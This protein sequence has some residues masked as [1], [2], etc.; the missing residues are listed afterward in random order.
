MMV[1]G[2]FFVKKSRFRQDDPFSRRPYLPTAV[3]PMQLVS[4]ADHCPPRPA[5][6]ST[7]TRA[8]ILVNRKTYRFFRS[9]LAN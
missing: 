8:H 5:G 2:P 7:D 9:G 6:V 1:F 4:L 3:R